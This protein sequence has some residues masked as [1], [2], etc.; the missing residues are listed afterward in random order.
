MRSRTTIILAA[1]VVVLAV[2]AWT[3]RRTEHKRETIDSG[4]IF[5]KAHWDAA[6]RISMQAAG[7]SVVLHK[8]DGRWLV[9]TEGDFPADTAAVS[10]IFSKTKSLDKRYRRAAS[11]ETHATFEVDDAH[12]TLVTFA[13]D[14]GATLARFRLG[15]NG[16]DFRSQFLR[17]SGSDEVYLIPEYLH[18]VFDVARPTWRD[19]S[20]FNFDQTKVKRVEFQPAGAL[21]FSVEKN[22]QGKFVFAGPD[23]TPAKSNLVES[24]VRTLAALRCDAFP[25]TIPLPG[26]AGLTPP[27]R[28]VQVELEDG[29]S[30]ALN[31]GAETK[32][33][34]QVYATRDGDPTIFLLTK[35]RGNSL[36]RDVAA[37]TEPPPEPPKETPL[38]PA[39]K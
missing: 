5:A 32:S 10:G 18:S 15:K 31:L 4:P 37:L 24:T 16:P 8:R 34:T 39:P 28:R 9:A 26:V 33:G 13:D 27:L 12:G 3:A 20:I 2:I 17:P 23:S 6:A 14:R 21:P 30:Y 22:A 35:G 25:D 11:P 1:I 19:R 38:I 7:D 29:A 36:V